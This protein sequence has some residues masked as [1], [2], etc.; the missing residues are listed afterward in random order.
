MAHTATKRF[1]YWGQLGILLALTGVGAILGG[2][3][4]L[5]PLMGKMDL[6]K[7]SSFS[8]EGLMTM[9]LNPENAN[10]VRLMQFIT[11]LFFFFLPA[12]FY[13]K[14]C[15]KNAFKHLGFIKMPSVQ[16][17]AIVFAIMFFALFIVGALAEIWQQIPFPKDWQLKF[18]AAEEMYSKQMQVM[19]RMNNVWDYIISLSIVA[20]L[21]AIFEEVIFRGALQ[22]LLSRWLK[23]PVWAIIITAI[24]F[25][26][27]HGS[28][29][30]FVP[31][32]VLGFILGWLFYRTGNIW[33]SIAAHFINNGIGITMLYFYSK[34]GK[35]TDLS[36][37]DERFPIWLG[38]VAV[39]AV[40]ALLYAF[41]KVSKDEINRPGQES[42]FPG[43]YNPN[44]PFITEAEEAANKNQV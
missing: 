22:N 39:I 6:T 26:A 43:Y 1:N 41:D 40:I 36:K 27:V 5:L 34:P 18:K 21:P 25:S 3:A 9:I 35:P 8:S 24:V 32:F 10:A 33:V 30:G 4:S 15:H 28:Y 17:L 37:I 29:D 2:I 13:A 42:L 31:R 20:L 19:A 7:L 11:T 44:N 23:A 14:I 16:Q 12:F 38:A